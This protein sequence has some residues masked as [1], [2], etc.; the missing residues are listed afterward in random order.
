MIFEI[1]SLNKNEIDI[2]MGN[3]KTTIRRKD[4]LFYPA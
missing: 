4:F 2:F 3:I 1:I